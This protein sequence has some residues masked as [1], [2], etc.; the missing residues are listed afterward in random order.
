MSRFVFHTQASLE[1]E[2]A[3]RWYE[4]Q[5]HGLGTQFRIEVEATLHRISEHPLG[6][7]SLFGRGRRAL[8]HRFPYGIIYPPVGE[9][10]YILS[11]FHTH[12]DPKSWKD[13]L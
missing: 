13:R 1:L 3:V 6:Y 11:F 8:V 10:I 4:Q 9:T 5:R 12:R 7:A 2:D